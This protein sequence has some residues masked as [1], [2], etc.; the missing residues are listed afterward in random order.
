M[1]H[2]PIARL[3]EIGSAPLERQ[4]SVALP[5]GVA[6]A[7]IAE[8]RALLRQKN[9]FYSF[10]SAL[11]V[12]PSGAGAPS[13]EGWNVASWRR[14][15][16]L[17]DGVLFFAQDLF[18]GQFAVMST[19]VAR[20]NPETGEVAPHSRTL[21]DWARRLLGD[22]NFETGWELAHE[23]QLQNGP[24]LPGHRLLP[25]VPFVLGGEYEPENLLAVAADVA[26]ENWG[27]LY[28]QLS[29]VPEGT[30]VS[31]TGWLAGVTL[32]E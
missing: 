12:F 2:D 14:H 23:W 29:G 26:M 28:D 7:V 31:V 1:T 4:E 27:R 3:L 20:F 8:L 18:G 30:E 15:Y 16:S 22:Y 13:L 19:G 11:H 9:G 32:A 5:Q 25:R 6:G 21:S 24:L 10:E 17:P